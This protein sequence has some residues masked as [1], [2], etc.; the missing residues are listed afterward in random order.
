MN[1]LQ[2]YTYLNRK[3]KVIEILQEHSFFPKTIKCTKCRRIMVLQ[4]TNSCKS[5]YRWYCRRP[6]RRTM[7]IYKNSYFELCQINIKKFL[8]YLYHFYNNIDKPKNILKELNM[9]PNTYYF[10]KRKIESAIIR[11]YILNKTR[12]RSIKK[13]VQVDESLFC[14]RKYNKGRWKKQIW[15]FVGIEKNTDK[16]FFRIVNNRSQ[17][18]LLLI[19][20]HEIDK[21]SEIVSDLWKAYINVGKNGYG[22]FTVNHKKYFVD[23]ITKRNTQKIENLWMHVK[24]KIHSDYGINEN[25]L[26][27]YLD[28]FS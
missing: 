20:N 18:T 4:K 6:C 27:T 2:F 23:P 9:S 3:S 1:Y 13:E 12:L 26:Q 8:L 16:C 17:E 21:G 14:R 25:A 24:K 5:G 28:I 11:D 19:I 10:Y 7:S 15:V 22:H